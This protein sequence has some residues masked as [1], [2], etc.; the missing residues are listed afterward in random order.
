MT[1]MTHCYH[2]SL[3]CLVVLGQ[4]CCNLG[5]AWQVGSWCWALL[6]L[7]SWWLPLPSA[8]SWHLQL[9]LWSWLRLLLGSWCGFRALLPAWWLRLLLQA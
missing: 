7:W 2:M 6:L 3:S 1:A 9:L 8:S 5:G 4:P